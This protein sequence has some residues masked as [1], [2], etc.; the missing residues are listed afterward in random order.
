[1]QH[2]GQSDSINISAVIMYACD[3]YKWKCIV[4]ISITNECNLVQVDEDNDEA[5][6]VIKKSASI[7]T[8]VKSLNVPS[9]R[10]VFL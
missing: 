6:T 9:V 4:K 3:K 7:D 2:G 10:L 8:F 5:S 1:M